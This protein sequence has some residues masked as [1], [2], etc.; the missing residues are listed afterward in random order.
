MSIRRD[1]VGGAVIVLVGLVIAVQARTFTVG[2]LTDPLGPKALPYLVAALLVAGG[3]GLIVAPGPG[4]DWP[5]AASWRRTATA[6]F[7]F[8]GY[9]ALLP[10]LGFLLATWGCMVALGWL[11]GAPWMR[12]AVGAGVFTVALY[13]VFSLLLGLTLPVGSWFT[14]GVS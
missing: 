11:F 4:T 10:M 12:N 14:I 3:A 2:F 13:V 9:A 5:D 1:R 7:A 6:M 8:I